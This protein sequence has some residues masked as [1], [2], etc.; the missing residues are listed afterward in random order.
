MSDLDALTLKTREFVERRGWERFQSPKN[1]AL[2]LCGEAG[3]LA[4]H[5]QWLTQAESWEITGDKRR[6][7]AEEMADVLIYLVRMA[8]ELDLD[9]V[10]AGLDK[11]EANERKYPVESASPYKS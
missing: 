11:A 9:L 10:A 3:E 7:V 1:L 8:D 5:F 6:K 4:E 2:A